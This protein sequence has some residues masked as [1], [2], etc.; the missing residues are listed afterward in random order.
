MSSLKTIMESQLE[1]CHD[2]T[3]MMIGYDETAGRALYE[4]WGVV[5]CT[6]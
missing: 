2:T 6:P 5:S 4:W 3:F 1:T